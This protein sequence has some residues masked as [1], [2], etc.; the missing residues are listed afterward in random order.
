MKKFGLMIA[1]FLVVASPSIASAKSVV[2]DRGGR[3]QGHGA[4]A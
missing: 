4:R 1:A 3:Q 2:I